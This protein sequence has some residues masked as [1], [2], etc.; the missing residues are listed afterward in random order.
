MVPE[1][2]PTEVI[3]ADIVVV[4][5]GLVGGLMSWDLS[6]KGLN[7]AMIDSGPLV[8]RAAAVRRFK[9]APIKDNS[10]PYVT[11]PYAPSP[12]ETDPWD[13][14][15]QKDHDSRD[16][17]KQVGFT[18]L[19]IRNVGGTSW[20]FTGHAER[21]YPNDFREKS[22]Y[23]R[24]EDWPISY[25][26]LVPYYERVE[27]AWG[28][29][30]DETCVAPEKHAYPL[31]VI[32]LT[33]LDEQVNKAAVALGDAVGPLP[34]CRNSVPY[35]FRPQC[36]GN[37]S[38]VFICPIGAKYDG[39]VHVMKAE[40]AGARLYHSHVVYKIEVGDD[41]KIKRLHY[42]NYQDENNP[43][44][45]VAKARVYVIAAHGIETPRLLLLSKGEHAPNGVA[46]SSDQVGRNLM[47]MGGVDS[48]AYVPEPVYPLRGP[49]NATA[50]FRGL[51]DGAFRKDFACIE[52]IIINGGFDE[53]SAP[54][55]EAEDAIK[56]GLL[57]KSLRN[58]VHN[59]TIRQVYID[60]AVEM[61]PNPDNRISLAKE[62][63]TF[64]DLPRPK[65][66][67]K[68]DEYTMEGI[69][70]SWVR[71]LNVLTQM[72]GRILDKN[73]HWIDPPK[74]TRENFDK[75]VKGDLDST[76]NDLAAG[77]ALISGTCRMGDDAKTSV[78]DPWCRSHDHDNLFIV[79][80]CNYVTSGVVSPSET[81]A[82]L[83]L[84]AADHIA[85][86]FNLHGG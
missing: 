60:N 42:A 79:G 21:M 62:R 47:S 14:Y 78:V 51:R 59:R 48:R 53:T 39:S 37:A 68:F 80:T 26:D 50:A 20:H 30:G 72:G 33:Y 44:Y 82:A 52:A 70:Q 43:V 34:Q 71:S 6:L 16:P 55:T 67:F 45:G 5:A 74:P 61:L 63:T 76:Y 81:A 24:G 58:R 65:I 86:T 12:G 56:A 84:R 3:D 54:I 69:Y 77:Y 83:G 38:C 2:T 18:G 75:L 64:M 85:A 73:G 32:P 19:Y 49:V 25:E 17:L 4:G 36:C 29:A 11:A 22:A 57:G 41:G 9:K 27:R 28:V 46:N 8:D 13:Y 15:V 1:R 40:T 31:P 66:N 35:D 23:G 10:A 7:V